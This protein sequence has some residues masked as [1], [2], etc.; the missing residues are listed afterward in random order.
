MQLQITDNRLR[1]ELEGVEH[2][3]AF[4]WGSAIEIRLDRIRSVSTEKPA[5]DW[6]R[7][8]RAPGTF[9]PGAIAAG[10]Y[11]TERGR[12]FW[13]A[14]RSRDFLVLTVADDYFKRI[15][16]TREDHEFWADRIAKNLPNLTG[17]A[18]GA[19]ESGVGSREWG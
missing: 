11:Y 14:T 5:I 7:V 19:S 18:M 1:I 15:V 10:T 2:L 6:Y 9:V 8:I 17:I 3:L 13:Y 12:E 4:Y 16:L